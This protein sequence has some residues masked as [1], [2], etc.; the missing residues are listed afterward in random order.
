MKKKPLPSAK[1]P[2]ASGV[3][4]YCTFT[5]IVPAAELADKL[6]KG[7][8]KKHPASNLDAAHAVV[9]GDGKH[10][11]N[12]WRRP[13]VVSSFSGM[14]TKGNGMVQM[15]LRHNLDVPIEIQSYKSR[16]E[17][18]RDLIADNALPKHSTDDKAALKKLLGELDQDE[19]AMTAVLVTTNDYARLQSQSKGR[20]ETRFTRF[21]VDPPT[22][23]ETAALLVSKHKLSK[24]I[25]RQIAAGAVPEGCLIT[26]GCNVRAALKDALGYLAATGAKKGAAA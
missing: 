3:P 26:A 12:G 10:A 21:H 24:A 2:L 17:E 4:V 22:V 7:N 19:L 6:W 11:G 23:D 14:V 20:L 18:I 8:M 16:R 1:L 13:V 9:V 25:A 5:K 15:A